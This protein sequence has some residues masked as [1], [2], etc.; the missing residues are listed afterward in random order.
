VRRG[1]GGQ[2]ARRS[3]YARLL[4]LRHVRLGTLTSFVL[5]EC[6]IAAAV[7]LALAE[8]VSWWAVAVLPLAVAAMVKLNDVVTGFLARSA[9]RAAVAGTSTPVRGSRLAAVPD[10]T[11]ARA[12]ARATAAVPREAGLS[13]LSRYSEADNYRF[14]RTHDTASGRHGTNSTNERR[15]RRSA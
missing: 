11:A 14:D 13:V 8:L 5:F 4:R 10:R 2:R 6:M 3:L 12:T 9:R 7:L 15:F 1:A